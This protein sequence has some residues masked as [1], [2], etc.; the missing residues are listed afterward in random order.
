MFLVPSRNVK[1]HFSTDLK[2]HRQASHVLG[3]CYKLDFPITMSK[4]GISASGTRDTFH[5]I[6]LKL[7]AISS[8][9]IF[10]ENALF[11]VLCASMRTDPIV[12]PA[13]LNYR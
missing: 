3:N 11:I 6:V 2:S 1:I 7:L 8:A 9:I 4:P 13:D 12:E 10:Y 5:S